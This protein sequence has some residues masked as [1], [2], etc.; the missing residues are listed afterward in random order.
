MAPGEDLEGLVESGEVAAIMAPYRG[1]SPDV[2]ALVNDPKSAELEWYERYGYI[3]IHHGIVVKND[4]LREH[5]DLASGLY[6]ALVASKQVFLDRLAKGEDVLGTMDRPRHAY[7]FETTAELV[8][9]ADPVPYGIE[10]NRPALEALLRYAHQQ[11]TLSR[12]YEV[13]DLF[14]WS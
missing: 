11:G 3:P 7:G 4:A 14:A 6:D 10:A 2:R 13:E 5:P 9:P 12:P 1:S 8:N